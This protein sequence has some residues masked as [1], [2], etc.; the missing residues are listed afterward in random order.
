M[1]LHFKKKRKYFFQFSFLT[2]S[3]FFYYHLFHKLLCWCYKF[4]GCVMSYCV[5]IN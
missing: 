1:Y 4:I 5:E 3:Y 2:K